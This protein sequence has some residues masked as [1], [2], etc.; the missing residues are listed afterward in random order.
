[1]L[2]VT[3]VI[4]TAVTH[5]V[6]TASLVVRLLPCCMSLYAF[7]AVVTAFQQRV[8]AGQFLTICLMDVTCKDG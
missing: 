2:I 8:C 4:S 7:V 3:T 1:M 6:D 5:I